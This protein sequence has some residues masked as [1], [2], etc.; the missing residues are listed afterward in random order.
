MSPLRNEREEKRVQRRRWEPSE[1]Q[2][3]RGI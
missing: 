1:K 2:W 3:E